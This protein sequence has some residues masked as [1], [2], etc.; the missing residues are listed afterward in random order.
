MKII[1][2]L[3]TIFS[4]SHA[5]RRLLQYSNPP[6]GTVTIPTNIPNGTPLPIFSLPVPTQHGGVV[7]IP[8]MTTK[9]TNILP[10]NNG[11]PMIPI[12]IPTGAA[13]QP[14]LEK[15]VV[16]HIRIHQHSVHVHKP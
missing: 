4:L 1:S 6:P 7:Q 5:D 2:V 8:P 10:N 14:I 11:Q 12:T 16:Y 3:L 9:G 13:L 15:N